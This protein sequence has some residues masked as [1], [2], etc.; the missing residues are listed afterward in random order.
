MTFRLFQSSAT[1]KYSS[2][3]IT[4]AIISS[5]TPKQWSAFHPNG[6]VYCLIDGG[7]DLRRH[8]RVDFHDN[9]LRLKHAT[10]SASTTKNSKMSVSI[11]RKS[12][13]FGTYAA[14]RSS[15]TVSGGTALRI[16]TLR[17]HSTFSRNALKIPSFTSTSTPPGP[18]AY[19]EYTGS[20]VLQSLAPEFN[21]GELGDGSGTPPGGPEGW[22]RLTSGPCRGRR[23]RAARGPQPA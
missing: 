22:R 14:I 5:E 2:V 13:S 18:Y 1:G 19:S 11:L 6:A 23:C 10:T 7:L 3:L 15:T 21:V 4:C 16:F 20:S 17:S 9:Q 8:L 12:V